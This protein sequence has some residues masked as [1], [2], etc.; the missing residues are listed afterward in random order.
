MRK[1]QRTIYDAQINI[2][3]PE[4][5][6]GSHLLTVSDLDEK[7]GTT[8][9]MAVTLNDR[10]QA[11]IYLRNGKELNPLTARYSLEDA[12]ARIEMSAHDREQVSRFLSEKSSITISDNGMS[13][14]TGDKGTDFIVISD[15]KAETEAITSGLSRIAG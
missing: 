14:E 15:P 2:T 10:I 4:Q 5:P 6:L 9:W 7:R 3:E 13:I 8:K 1:Q 12:L 11:K